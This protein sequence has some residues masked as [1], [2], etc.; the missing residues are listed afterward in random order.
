MP[1]EKVWT[2]TPMQRKHPLPG[3]KVVCT[4]VLVPI[5]VQDTNLFLKLLKQKSLEIVAGPLEHAILT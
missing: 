5:L 1:I 3:V 2:A 4:N